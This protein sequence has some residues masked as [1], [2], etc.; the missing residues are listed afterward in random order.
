MDDNKQP[1]VVI[2]HSIIILVTMKPQIT[3]TGISDPDGFVFAEN[4]LLKIMS[5]IKF[6]HDNES[7]ICID[8]RCNQWNRF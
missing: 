6:N 3:V 8:H 1:V 7:K 4:T 5:P 2:P